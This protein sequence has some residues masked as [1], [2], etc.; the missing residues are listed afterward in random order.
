MADSKFLPN[1]FSTPNAYCD[2]YMYLLTPE[3]WK[4]LS[5]AARRIFGFQKRQDRI[6]LSQFCTG[7]RSTETGDVLDNG[8]GLSKPAVMKALG[9]LAQ[10]GLIVKLADNNARTN[11]GDLWSLQLDSAQVDQAGL[12]ARRN[13]HRSS[14]AAATQPARRA[15]ESKRRSIPLTGLACAEVVNGI[16]RGRSIALTGG[17]QWHLPG[18]VNGID[19]QKTVGKPVE[20]QSERQGITHPIFDVALATLKTQYNGTFKA[21][22][23]RLVQY[24]ERPNRLIVLVDSNPAGFES[25]LAA[26]VKSSTRKRF[27]IE[28]V[29]VWPPAPEPADDTPA[30]TLVRLHRFHDDL[31]GSPC[32]YNGFDDDALLWCALN[33]SPEQYT[34]TFNALKVDK[35]YKHKPITPQAIAKHISQTGANHADHRTDSR[36]DATP[37]DDDLANLINT[38]SAQRLGL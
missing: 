26:A 37:A 22:N 25:N 38:E 34:A 30:L 11:E 7:T 29:T 1:S 15:A 23:P 27:A 24:D 12:L 17:G 18:A 6:S 33:Y 4:V 32:F 16:D 21:I 19:T 35:F 10:Y 14:R 2:E 8:T 5:Y 20:N 28:V 13:Q 3:E 31:V 36:T 9:T